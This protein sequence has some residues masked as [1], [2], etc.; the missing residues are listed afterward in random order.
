MVLVHPLTGVQYNLFPDSFYFMG[1]YFILS[2]GELPFHRCAW[3]S[4]MSNLKLNSI[5]PLLLLHTKHTKSSPRKRY[6][7]RNEKSVALCCEPSSTH[8][9]F[10]VETKGIPINLPLTLVWF[11]LLQGIEI[12]V[13]HAVT[14]QSDVL[15]PDS[16]SEVVLEEP[17]FSPQPLIRMHNNH[18]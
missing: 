18:P 11:L 12:G 6:R 14:V 9:A 15:H 2:Q 8:G 10:A 1:V 16:D 4:A 17:P 13:A 7:S 3:F 5:C